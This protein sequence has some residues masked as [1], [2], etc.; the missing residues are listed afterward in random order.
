[1]DRFHAMTVFA[2]VVEQGSFARAAERLDISTSACSRLVADLGL[3]TVAQ[4]DDGRVL[5]LDQA[6]EPPAT[7]AVASATAQDGDAALPAPPG[8]GSLHCGAHR[9]AD[10]KEHRVAQ[11]PAHQR[12]GLAADALVLSFSGAPAETANLMAMVPADF[13]LYSG[14]AGSRRPSISTNASPISRT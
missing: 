12:D 1:M 9:L 13:E 4:A 8:Q 5:L 14:D 6:A 3:E 2:K 7:V 11:A 10:G